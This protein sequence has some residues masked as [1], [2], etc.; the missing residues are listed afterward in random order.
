MVLEQ[1]TGFGFQWVEQSWIFS[2]IIVKYFLVAV[3]V[4]TVV[5]KQ[6]L[7]YYLNRLIEYSEN[8][9]L[10]VTGLGLLNVF[11]GYTL[12]PVLPIISQVASLLYFALLF[13]KF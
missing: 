2:T 5:E 7:E 1:L 8:L 13:W 6:D 3:G 10:V 4:E 9:V 12:E 11:A